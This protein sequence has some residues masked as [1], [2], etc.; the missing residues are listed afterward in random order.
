M[1]SLDFNLQKEEGRS[2]AVIRNEEVARIGEFCASCVV[3]AD[4]LTNA[5]QDNLT[6]GIQGGLTQLTRKPLH[7]F[8][9]EHGT[10]PKE[11][12]KDA[13]ESAT[14]VQEDYRNTRARTDRNPRRIK[15]RLISYL[16]GLPAQEYI[17]TRGLSPYQD[18]SAKLGSSPNR[19][20]MVMREMAARGELVKEYRLDRKGHNVAAVHF[21]E[22]PVVQTLQLGEEDPT[23][24]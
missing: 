5:L 9:N 15:S 8:F 23:A 12:L 3:R 2:R 1:T 4:C 13:L 14:M 22:Q 18:I 24:A 7:K 21:V 11:T 6:Y 17:C 10:L 19:L 20:R 16:Q